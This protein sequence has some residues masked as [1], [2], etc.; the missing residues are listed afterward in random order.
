MNAHTTRTVWAAGLSLLLVPLTAWGAFTDVLPT[1]SFAPAIEYVESVGVVEG[2]QDGTYRPLKRLNRAEF[3]TMTMRA[4]QGG[5]TPPDYDWGY[6]GGVPFADIEPAAWYAPYLWQATV[7]GVVTGDA[8]D[9]ATGLGDVVR[10]NG[11]INYAEAAKI[12]VELHGVPVPTPA[13]N[14][15]WAWYTGYVKALA[16]VDAT[17]RAGIGA[18]EVVTRADM[19]VMLY[20]LHLAGY[21][22]TLPPVV[23][24]PM[25]ETEMGAVTIEEYFSY[26]CGFCK[27]LHDTIETVKATSA[28]PVVVELKHF[29]IYT[30]Y[31]AI[32]RGQVCAAE[33]GVGAEFHDRYFDDYFGATAQSTAEAIAEAVGADMTDF[34][35]CM[36]S[37][38]PDQI[39]AA[40]S[41]TARSLKAR[42]TPFMR[43]VGPDG[44]TRN[45][46]GALKQVDLERV[47][48]EM[49]RS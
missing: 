9:A 38:L 19:A 20:Q 42:G 46:P 10:P 11:D 40:H 25:V 32:H 5:D 12:V 4:A 34:A 15:R 18:S 2:Y 6:F 21:A 27:R 49:S 37:D 30:Q 8:P 36:A 41:A 17:P 28:V 48:L 44:K 35:T 33:Q 26:G 24:E 47:L 22:P 39:I 3:V 43:L 23:I 31:R 29:M 45:V 1:S 13:P 7:R 14:E 16:A